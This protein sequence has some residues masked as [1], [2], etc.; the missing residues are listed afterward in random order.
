MRIKILDLFAGAGGF[1]LGLELVTDKSGRKLFELHR[2]V[3]ID[4]YACETLRNQY[5]GDRVIEGD[6]TDKSNHSRIIDECRGVVSVIIGGIPCQ[7]FS[8]IGPRSG[9]GKYVEKYKQDARDNLYEEFREIVRELRPEV[10]VIENVKGILSKKDKDGKRI[11][12]KLLSDFEKLD[13]SFE[14]DR[15]QKK[16]MIL[17]A[18][19]FGVPQTRARVVLMGI[20]KKWKKMLVPY[21]EATHF[22]PHLVRNNQLQNASLMSYTTLFDAIG[23][24][25]EVM[26]K[27]TATGLRGSMM[28]KRERMNADI[29]SG[30]D[31]SQLE[32]TKMNKHL[33]RLGESGSYYFQFIRPDNYSF[34]DHHMARPQQY[35]DIMLFSRMKEGETAEEFLVRC[36]RSGK[37]LIKYKMNGFKDK[38]RKQ[39]WD[40]PCT[41]IFAHLEKDGNRF[42]HPAQPR[43][44]TPREAA[45]IQSFPDSYIFWGPVS[46]KYKQIGNAV[47]P[48]MAYNIGKALLRVFA[49]EV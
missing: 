30:N 19:D 23:D 8:L 20:N 36:P 17:N 42:I 28:K 16:Y 13:Y 12:E 34:I 4:R 11:I 21:V 27:I 3:E 38:Y 2:A 32:K 5:G 44:I 41:T 33:T 29:N 39:R 14:N 1:S 37:R 35:S 18:A 40:R 7:S 43:T 25:P 9:Y 46:K 26:P 15:D 6:L 45:R 24:L 10:I 49:Y 48:L 31:K 22:D 47:P